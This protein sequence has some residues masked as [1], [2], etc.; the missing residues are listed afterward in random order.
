MNRQFTL[1]AT[2][3][4]P[5]DVRYGPYNKHLLHKM[6]DLLASIGVRRV[7]WLYCGDTD[8]SSYWAGN[9]LAQMEYGPETVA[10]I[11]EPLRAAAPVAHEHGLEIYGVLKPYNTGLSWGTPEGA[12]GVMPSA[13]ARIGSVPDQV[14]PFLERHP[15]TRMRRVSGTTPVDLRSTP[16]RRIRLLKSDDSPT[17]IRRDNLQIWTS[18]NNF[19]Y[20]RQNVGFQ[21]DES[22]QPSPREVRDYNGDLVVASGAPARTLTI[23]GLE[24]IEP[25]VLITSPVPFRSRKPSGAP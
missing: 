9:L 19:E 24:L 23:S 14:I 18:P 11:G 12:S 6:M 20:T 13:V 16:V 10:N 17:R 3:D 7:Y 2:V 1:S 8:Q 15:N 4:F 22:V 5:D 21:V 25:Y